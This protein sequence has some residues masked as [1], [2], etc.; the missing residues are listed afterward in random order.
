MIDYSQ[1]EDSERYLSNKA[2][3]KQLNTVVELI[4]DDLEISYIDLTSHNNF[5]GVTQHN[6]ADYLIPQLAV[7]ENKNWNCYNYKGYTVTMLKAKTEIST[8]NTVL[9]RNGVG[10]LLGNFI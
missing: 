9:L 8:E 7:I 6:E 4:L 3:E 1:I 2:K 5:I 10:S